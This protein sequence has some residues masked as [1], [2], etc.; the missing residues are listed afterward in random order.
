MISVQTSF[1]NERSCDTT[2]TVVS[3]S[4]STRYLQRCGCQSD[5]VCSTSDASSAARGA[6]VCGPLGM[7]GANRGLEKVTKERLRLEDEEGR[8][9]S[10]ITRSLHAFEGQP[11]YH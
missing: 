1:K 10:E 2:T 3:V 4:S 9:D 11:H 5:A 7:S 6:G 8:G